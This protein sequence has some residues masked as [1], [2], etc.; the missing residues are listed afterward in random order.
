MTYC[1]TLGE[2]DKLILEETIKKYPKKYSEYK[3]KE[4]NKAPFFY[5]ELHYKVT[6]KA[7]ELMKEALIN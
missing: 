7:K 6:G 3:I 2:E 1:E 4:N 5:V